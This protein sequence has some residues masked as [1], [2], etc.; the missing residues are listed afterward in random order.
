[1]FS[2]RKRPL[3][4]PSVPRVR[5]LPIKPLSVFFLLVPLLPESSNI[6]LRGLCLDGCYGISCLSACLYLTLRVRNP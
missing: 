3:L 2:F 5:L 6:R 4:S 1:M